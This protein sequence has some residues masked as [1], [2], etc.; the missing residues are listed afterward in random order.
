MHG[1][2]VLKAR[3]TNTQ[4]RL[5]V[6]TMARTLYPIIK[7]KPFLEM[8]CY[9]ATKDKGAHCAGSKKRTVLSC[10]AEHIR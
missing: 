5:S 10:T 6:N 3:E 4:D 7:Q 1:H 2:I 8:L 9:D